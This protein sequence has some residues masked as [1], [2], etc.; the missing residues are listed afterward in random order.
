ML[1]LR[2]IS[3]NFENF[4]LKNLSFRL[5]QGDYLILLGESG[6]GKSL[7]LEM[8]AGL[9]KPDSGDLSCSKSDSLVAQREIGLLF[10]DYALF[11]HMTV[12]DNIAYPIHNWPAERKKAR[13]KEMAEKFAITH[14][15]HRK[16]ATLSGGE[17]QRVAL[18]RTLA[19]SPKILLL[20]EPMSALDVQLK[21]EFR[22]IF[23]RLNREGLS[24]IHVTHDYE[25]AIALGNKIIVLQN[26]QIVQQGFVENVFQN[27]ANKF[28]ANLTGVRNFYSATLEGNIET[29][30]RIAIINEK[31]HIELI[32][33]MNPG[34]GHVS[35]RS[36]DILLSFDKLQSSASNNFKGIITDI[37][38]TPYGIEV[39][40]DI[41]IPIVAVIS[42]ESCKNMGINPGSEIWVAF[43]ASAVKF[44]K[45]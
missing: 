25:E 21:F 36:R 28:V 39:K 10:Q 22:S 6:S 26:G 29:G 37:I 31:I 30:H 14:L 19:L 13:I 43:K 5:N 16:P 38:P 4:Q 8:I 20:D 33:G 11:P 18:A 9:L 34:N 17:Q 42:Q 1:E 27:P 23:K 2:N 24:I 12:R 45:S 7:I 15:L 41:G 40:I 35:V 32:S 3:K 44:Y